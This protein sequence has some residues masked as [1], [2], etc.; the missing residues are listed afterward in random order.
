[1]ELE[2]LRCIESLLERVVVVKPTYALFS[3]EMQSPKGHLNI[4]PTLVLS[5]SSVEGEVLEFIRLE[6]LNLL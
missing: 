6:V 3:L 4:Y 2:L 5:R 1:M